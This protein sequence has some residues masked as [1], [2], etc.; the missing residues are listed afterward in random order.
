MASILRFITRIS[1][2]ESTTA[3]PGLSFNAVLNDRNVMA[4]LDLPE[5]IHDIN[6]E[7]SLVEP[8]S[9]DPN[10]VCAICL[11]HFTEG[12]PCKLSCGH[13]LHSSCLQQLCDHRARSRRHTLSCP[14]C[15]R[16]LN[17]QIVHRRE[18]STEFKASL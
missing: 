6:V 3:P 13:L 8:D 2:T 18:L 12:T 4:S 10:E 5:E 17:V 15:R 14:V 9:I 1:N 7:S 16:N 11:G